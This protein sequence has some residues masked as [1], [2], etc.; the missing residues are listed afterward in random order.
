MASNNKAQGNTT[1]ERLMELFQSR[2]ELKQEFNQLQKDKLMLTKV[3]E[4]QA[5]KLEKLEH[6]LEQLERLLTKPEKYSDLKVY[7]QLRKLWKTCNRYIHKFRDRLVDQ[8]QDRERKQQLMDFNQIKSEKMSRV[9]KEI[10]QGKKLLEGIMARVEQISS[11]IEAAAYP[12]Q[13]LKKQRLGK[14]RA[15]A[16]KTQTEAYSE[17][18]AL[19]DKRIK[20]E[21][22]PWPEFDGLDLEGKRSINLAMIAL[23]QY[24]FMSLTELGL[25][26]KTFKAQMKKPWEC[27]YG[28]KA[29]QNEIIL[30]CQQKLEFFAKLKDLGNE[31]QTRMAKLKE[32]IAYK[33][34]DDSIPDPDTIIKLINDISGASLTT[35]ISDVNL[36][37]NVLTDNYWGIK[38]LMIP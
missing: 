25:A 31:V 9:N 8:Q 7:Y 24:F 12:W 1:E 10:E 35:T 30:K 28:T 26:N 20:I 13:F 38:D 16:H 5:H 32:A 19:Y 22:E 3:S 6:D 18:Q 11:E 27:S 2:A 34:H 29:E 14:Q 15:V 4:D 37:V 23:G 33:K 17:L 36:E 21:S